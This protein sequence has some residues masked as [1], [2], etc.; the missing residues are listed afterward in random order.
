MRRNSNSW[1][2]STGNLFDPLVIGIGGDA[3]SRR[4]SYLMHADFLERFH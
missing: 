2:Y 3:V 1:T 4:V